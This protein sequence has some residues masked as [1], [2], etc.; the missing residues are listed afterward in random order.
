MCEERDALV[1]S[2]DLLVRSADFGFKEVILDLKGSP[3]RPMRIVFASYYQA[4]NLGEPFYIML[5]PFATRPRWILA[6]VG[7]CT[8]PATN[9]GSSPAS[10]PASQQFAQSLAW[11]CSRSDLNCQDQWSTQLANAVL[12]VWLSMLPD[13]KSI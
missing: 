12:S 10:Q 2:H 6:L 1:R 3:P 5:H 7:S 13:V 9:F 8:T 4:N 11:R